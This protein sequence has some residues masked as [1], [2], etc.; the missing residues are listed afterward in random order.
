MTFFPVPNISE[1]IMLLGH[2]FPEQQLFLDLFE[3]NH[4]GQ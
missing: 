2:Y 3:D 4:I 1:T